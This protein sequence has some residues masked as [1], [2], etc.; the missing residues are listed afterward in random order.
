MRRF[1]RR[2]ERDERGA[3][4]V[5][6]G[7]VSVA[8]FAAAAL[9][10]DYSSLVMERQNLHDHIDSA[11]HA[12]AY[13]L[14]GN[15]ANAAN[16]AVSMA[17]AQ[18]PSLSP[19][20]DLYCVV[21]STGT[22][23]TVNATQIPSTCYPGPAPYSSSAYPGLR[24]NAKICA[25]PCKVSNTTQCNTITVSENK[26][27]DFTFGRVIGV[28]T[29]DTGSVATAA[30]KGSCG[31]E[32]PN[33]LD[34]VIMADRTPSMETAD[35]QAMQSAILETLKTM[36]PKL[37]YVSFGTI[38][39]SKTNPG[40]GCITAETGSSEGAE[41]GT[42][43]PVGFRDDYLTSATTPTLN[44]T[45]PLVKGVRCLPASENGGYGT[46]LAS[47]LKFAAKKLLSTETRGMPARPGS[48]PKKI[49][50]LE[51]DG[52]PE[53]TIKRA[54]SS[55]STNSEIGVDYRESNAGEAGCNNL[56]KM[57]KEVKD[58]GITIIT[59]GFGGAATN[60]CNR[61]GTGT[62]VRDVLA[63]A[64][65]PDPATGAASTAGDCS[66]TSGR[67]KENTDGD[68]FFCAVTGPEMAPL[69]KTAISQVSNSIRMLQMP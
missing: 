4:A 14:P 7:L 6:V 56:V 28:P 2:R 19:R 11:A 31:D 49:L 30:C 51:T 69:F 25:I 68:F 34:V 67:Q 46:H 61:A 48:T 8:L 17:T 44:E 32:L 42:W 39:K 29:G 23:R 38:H 63:K 50:V 43:L 62:L 15:A 41:A 65:S 55:L 12:G 27:V 21:A 35:R 26:V 37:H 18:D 53:E 52:R 24:C 58:A 10:V 9:A 45:S 13:E 47:P 22:A 66:T 3:T 40:T 16:K 20:A 59:I 60:K 5:L 54:Y 36:N 64:A 57:A 33:P 1:F